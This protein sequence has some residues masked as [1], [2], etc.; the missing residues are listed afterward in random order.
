VT[1]GKKMYT[2]QYN[3]RVGLVYESDVTTAD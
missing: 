3:H 1:G 2:I